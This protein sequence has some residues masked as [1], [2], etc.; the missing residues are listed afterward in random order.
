[1]VRT[2]GSESAAACH[3]GEDSGASAGQS[4]GALARPYALSASR[5]KPAL[6]FE[7]RHSEHD[8]AVYPGTMML[9]N[10]A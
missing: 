8:D 4:R 1:M 7:C 5:R 2:S 9:E 3:P 6:P 10:A